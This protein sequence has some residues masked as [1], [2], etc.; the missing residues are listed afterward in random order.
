MNT[1]PA[2]DSVSSVDH[3]PALLCPKGTH[4]EQPGRRLYLNTRHDQGWRVET[5]ANPGQRIRHQG[6]LR[7]SATF[8]DSPSVT[9]LASRIRIFLYWQNALRL[10]SCLHSRTFRTSQRMDSVGKL[11]L[12]YPM[13]LI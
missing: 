8:R 2:R 13:S 1:I 10:P 4:R 9:L 3:S 7:L 12:R 11:W 6:L 5:S